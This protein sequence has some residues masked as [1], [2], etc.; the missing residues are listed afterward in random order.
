MQ[1]FVLPLSRVK[2]LDL[3]VKQLCDEC[4]SRTC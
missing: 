1:Y 3:A 2:K 4:R